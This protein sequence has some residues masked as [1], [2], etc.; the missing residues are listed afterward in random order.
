MPRYR[1]Q[2]DINYNG[3]AVEIDGESQTRPEMNLTVR[4][5]LDNFTRHGDHGA[6]EKPMMYFEHEVPSFDD[7]T[8]VI[9]YKRSLQEQL[10]SVEEFI[11]NNKDEESQMG[12]DDPKTE[13]AEV[14]PGGEHQS[15]AAEV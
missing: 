13:A 15:T 14:A 9:N 2:F 11:K 7:V 1:V 10:Q 6:E 3:K 5:L 8:D 12:S 4:Q